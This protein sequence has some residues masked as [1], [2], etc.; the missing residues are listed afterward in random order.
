VAGGGRQTTEKSKFNCP[1]PTAT[2]Q[3]FL[4]AAIQLSKIKKGA[5][6]TGFSMKPV[7]PLLQPR[8]LFV[9]VLGAG[10]PLPLY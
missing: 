5:A 8:K 7:Y 6:T 4:F 9:L 1:M 3:L 2:S 10:T